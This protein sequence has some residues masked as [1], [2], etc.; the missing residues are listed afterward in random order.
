MYN[1][2]RSN[3]EGDNNM[4]KIYKLGNYDGGMISSAEAKSE[5][6]AVKS[7]PLASIEDCKN[8]CGTC[9]KEGLGWS[10]GYA[11]KIKVVEGIFEFNFDT[12][13]YEQVLP[14]A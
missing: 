6:I 5:G 10:G 9:V 3:L 11:G 7:L 13:I 8:Y 4:H 1:E 14:N 2:L 12:L